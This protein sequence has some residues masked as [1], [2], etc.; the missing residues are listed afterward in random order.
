MGATVQK[1]QANG[2]LRIVALTK[3]PENLACFKTYYKTLEDQGALK[4][5]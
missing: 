4:D 1:K 2:S 5:V 3:E